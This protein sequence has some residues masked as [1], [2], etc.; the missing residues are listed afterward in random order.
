MIQF[1]RKTWVI[2]ICVV[3]VV[4]VGI[5]ASMGSGVPVRTSVVVTKGITSYVEERGRTSLPHIYHVTMPME[6]RVLPIEIEEGD[7]VSEGDIVARLDDADWL[8]ATLETEGII[9]AVAKWVEAAEASVKA[10]K[11]RQQHAQWSWNADKKLQQTKTISEKTARDSKFLFLDSVVK[12]DAN[13]A[14]L[15]MSTS[16][17]SIMD[18]LPGYVQRRLDRTLVKSPVSGTILKRHVWNE[19]VV[20]SGT[21]LLDIGNLEELEVTADVLTESAVYIRPG[22]RVEIFGEAIGAETIQGIVR[23]VEPEAFTKISSLG[24]EEQR[25]TVKISFDDAALAAL[26]DKGKNLGLQYRVRVKVITD[27]K[28]SALTIPRTALFHGMKGQ[29][30]VYRVVSGKARLA[31]VQIGL[32]NDYEAEIVGGIEA[33]DEVVVAP[34]SSITDGTD[35]TA[36]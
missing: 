25:V 1:S 20:S 4:V 36:L 33:G 8:D 34:E 32:M 30:Q 27:E 9:D 26:K 5:V 29:W 23:I 12:T 13:Q 21:P 18:L 7:I 14:M 6:G 35:V 19:K 31:D 24:V 10:S 15:E 28:S 2:L 17:Q 11:N 16:I 22:D 3:A